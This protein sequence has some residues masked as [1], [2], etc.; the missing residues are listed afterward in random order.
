MKYSR[1]TVMSPSE[2]MSQGEDEEGVRV[3]GDLHKREKI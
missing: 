3:G 2:D 1:R